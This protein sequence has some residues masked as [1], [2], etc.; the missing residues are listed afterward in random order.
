MRIKNLYKNLIN[1]VVTVVAVLFAFVG[2]GGYNSRKA[3]ANNGW[4]SGVSDSTINDFVSDATIDIMNIEYGIQN[5]TII[6]DGQFLGGYNVYVGST[7][8]DLVDSFFIQCLTYE[9]NSRLEYGMDL[10][11]AN[12]K[13]LVH[14]SQIQFVDI[15][16]GTEYNISNT[17]PLTG[18]VAGESTSEPIYCMGIWAMDSFL[19]NSFKLIQDS[20]ND[21]VVPV[22]VIERESVPEA[23]NGL[24]MKKYCGGGEWEVNYER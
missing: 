16:T 11:E 3:K 13:L 19:Y 23:D 6:I 14:I 18:I 5:S 21:Y 17:E 24:S 9:I 10:T 4:T 7:L 15:I 12:I 8:N 20:V 22:Y 1:F 2:F